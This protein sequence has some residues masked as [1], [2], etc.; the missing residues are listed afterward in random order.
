ME[1]VSW[2]SSDRAEIT[3][4]PRK[5][6]LGDCNLRCRTLQGPS[7]LSPSPQQPVVFPGAAL[8][9]E[10]PSSHPGQA[11][12]VVMAVSLVGSWGQP[13]GPPPGPSLAAQLSRGPVDAGLGPSLA[14]A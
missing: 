4:G 9:L 13:Q 6:L 11:V 8:D 1:D 5:T 14:C 2:G 7:T 3:L 10:L 12:L